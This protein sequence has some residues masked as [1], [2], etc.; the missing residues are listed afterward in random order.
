MV[1]SSTSPA[2][3]PARLADLSDGR[4]VRLL[5]LTAERWGQVLASAESANVY[6]CDLWSSQK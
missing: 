5:M 4:R 1:G 6:M 2:R 3:F